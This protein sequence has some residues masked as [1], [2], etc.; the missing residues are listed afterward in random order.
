[1]NRLISLDVFRGIAIAG[2]ILVNMVG[3]ADDKYMLLDHAAWNGCTLADLV[4]PFF[5]FAIGLAMAY[6][7]PRQEAAKGSGIYLHVLKRAALL[8]LI[9]LAIS[10][11]WNRGIWTFDLG[12]IRFMGILQRIALAY[13]GASFIVLLLPRPG[14]WFAAAGL[15]IGTWLALTY[16]P[17][18]EFGSGVLTRE[19]NFGAYV[20]RLLIPSDHL[21]RG[22]NYN[23]MGDP[24]G[25]FGSLAAIVSI[26]LGYFCGRF[27]K[28]KPIAS[29]TALQLAL[30]G[31]ACLLV[32]WG[33]DMIF[34]VNKKLWTSS[35]VL[36]TGGGAL[37]LYAALYELIEVRKIKAWSKPLEIMGLNAIVLFVAHAVSIKLLIRLRAGSEEGAPNLYDWVYQGAFVPMAG[38]VNGS[39]L[40]GIVSVLFWLGVGT[41]MYRQ[42]WFVRI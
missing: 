29:K 2:M 12:A 21:Y 17:V 7:L 24:E 34:P 9:G 10:G 23:R 4:F 1:M 14:Q 16:A 30:C 27:V 37:V 28:E 26:L 33:W 5:M 18:P 19:G 8:F 11:F 41:V 35:Y 38:L 40:W 13:L 39:L 32:G 36:F 20:D 42:R 25:V 6:S 31:I 3:I 15:L 22:D